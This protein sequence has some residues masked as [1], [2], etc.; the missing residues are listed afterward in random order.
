MTLRRFTHRT[1]NDEDRADEIESHLVHEQ[2]A[3][4]ARRQS[5][6]EVSSQAQLRFGNPGVTQERGW[7][8]RSFPWLEEGGRDLRFAVRSLARTPGFT[9]IG[10]LIIAVGIGVKHRS[11]FSGGCCT[12]QAT[13]LSRSAGYGATG[14]YQQPGNNSGREHPRVQHLAGAIRHLPAG[15]CLRLGRSWN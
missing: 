7:L 1:K 6:Q 8:Y 15:G 5:P 12:S 4:R 3:N 10:L 11:L 9:S 14:D 13:D 2:D